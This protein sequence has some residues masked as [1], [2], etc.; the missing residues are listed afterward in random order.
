MDTL[1]NRAG[2]IGHDSSTAKAPKAINTGSATNDERANKE[3]SAT[4]KQTNLFCSEADTAPRVEVL[5][6]ETFAVRVGVEYV[7]AG[8]IR[9]QVV[10]CA[11]KVV[12]GGGNGAKD[13][14][15]CKDKNGGAGELKRDEQGNE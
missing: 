15:R 5:E 11:S 14:Q 6:F 7:V 10:V 12:H 2:S 3:G 4:N 9:E 13:E 8:V 1:Q